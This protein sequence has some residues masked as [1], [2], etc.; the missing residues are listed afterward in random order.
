MNR[1]T[2]DD[3]REQ[4]DHQLEKRDGCERCHGERG[5]VPG[6]ENVVNGVVLCDYCHA[7]DLQRELDHAAVLPVR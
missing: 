1:R 7:D 5:G 6:N 3:L 2:F 4:I